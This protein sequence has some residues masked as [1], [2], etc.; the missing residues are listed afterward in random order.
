MNSFIAKDGL[1]WLNGKPAFIQAGEFHYYRTPVDQWEHRLGLLKAAGFNAVASYIPWLWH[2]VEEGLSDLDGHSHPMRDLGGFLDLAA[3]MGFWLIPRPGPY[4]MAETTNEGIPPWVFRNYPQVAFIN[5]HGKPE[6]VVS[7]LQPDFLA[8]VQKWY[9]AVFA[10]LAPRQISRGGKILMVQLDNEM[11]MIQ[12]VRNILD[13]NSDTLTRFHTYL[14]ANFGEALAER[15]PAERLGELL[16]AAPG[17]HDAGEAGWVVEEYRRFYRGYLREYTEFLWTEARQNGLETP[18][19][20]NIHGFANGGKTF[21]IGISQLIQ[22]M[23]IEGM[24]SATDVYPGVIGEGNFHQLLMVNEMTKA[25]HNPQQPLFSIEFQA[26]GNLDFSNGQSSMQ[27]LHSRL[28]ISSG[29][30]A[31]NHYLFC[32]GE[33]DPILSPTWRHDWGHP[34]RTDGSLRKQFGRYA[35]LSQALEA[36][37]E[38]LV[39]ARPKTVTT[40]GY[41]LDYFMTEVN[42]PASRAWSD[43]ITQQ[44]DTVLFDCIGRGLAL[45]HRPFEALELE[46][47]ELD[48][49]RTPLLWVMM[50]RQCNAAVQRKLVE[51]VQ[52]GGK[53]ILAGRMC[54]E[55]FNHQP[56]TILKEALGIE[57]IESDPDFYQ[58]AIQVFQY[59]QVPVSFVESYQGAFSEVFARDEAGRVVGFVQS[60][61]QGEALLFGAAMY[62]E[63][64]GDID[65]VH[66][67]ALRMGCPPLF[68]LS[69]W[70]DVRVNEGQQGSFLFINNYQDD[71]LETVLESNGQRLFGGQ[72]LKVAARSGMILPLEWQVAP[73]VLL[74]Y[75]TAE[76]CSVERDTASLTLS[77]AQPEFT[78]ELSLDGYRCDGASAAVDASSRRIKLHANDGRIVLRQSA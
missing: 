47:G 6:N 26:G 4:I 7:Y 44:R 12:W 75:A 48:P 2:Q 77:T 68:Q 30:R 33:N 17:H 66:Q 22:V 9:A 5:Q 14:K 11:G 62:T 3:R 45:T 37:G 19:V 58:K 25:V 40:I 60:L 54:L 76:I 10:V 72:T 28:C 78:A 73:G 56:C 16:Q 65:I 71:P 61:G 23:E 63:T 50:E 49:A 67:M 41:L 27:D 38:D 34:V 35:R 20:I 46:R 59:A 43:V 15:Y 1:F 74:H 39:T 55:E 29:M 8:C 18:P 21:P 13:L 32:G 42:T 36:Y 51:Y 52:A 69:D 24:L 64:L 53:L 31:I 57:Q 70:A